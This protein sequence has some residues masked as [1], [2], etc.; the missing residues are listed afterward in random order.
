ME[1][2][3]TAPYEEARDWYSRNNDVTIAKTETKIA[4]GDH[5]E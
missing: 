2:D 3:L 1:A 4:L 5:F